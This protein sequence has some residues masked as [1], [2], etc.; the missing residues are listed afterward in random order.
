M[1]DALKMAGKTHEFILIPGADHQM[2]RESDRIT[3]L[4]AIEKFLVQNL[5]PGAP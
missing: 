3:L 5:G 4:T 1:D 2:G